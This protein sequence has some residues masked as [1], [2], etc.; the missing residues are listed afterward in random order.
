MNW[1]REAALL[2]A[3]HLALRSLHLPPSDMALRTCSRESWPAAQRREVPASHLHPRSSKVSPVCLATCRHRARKAS[4]RLQPLLTTHSPMAVASLKDLASMGTVLNRRSRRLLQA[5]VSR[6]LVLAVLM[7][8]P[9][10]S[11]ASR[12]RTQAHPV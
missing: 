8:L 3:V 11:K 12:T 2:A 7:A 1:S 4:M 6:A 9:R 10:L 5:Q